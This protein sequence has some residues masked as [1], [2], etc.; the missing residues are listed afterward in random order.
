MNWRRDTDAHLSKELRFH[1]DEH[2]DA[3]IAQGVEPGEAQRRARLALG[4]VEQVKEQLRD[5]R[6]ARWLDELSQ[7]LRYALRTL[8]RRPAFAAVVISTIALGAGAT[9]VMFTVINS[10]LLKPLAYPQ[11]ER[12]VTLQ[13][14]TEVGTQYGNRWAFAYPN[15]LDCERDVRSLTLAAWRFALGSVT[16][17][18]DPEYVYGRQISA[19]LFSMLSVPVIQGRAFSEDEDRPGTP[20]VAVIG[21]GLWQRHY[22]GSPTAVGQ[23]IVFDGKPYTVIGVLPASFPFSRQPPLPPPPR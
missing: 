6:P 14:Q 17:P 1:I 4:G 16:Q 2:A 8:A 7:D 15:Y 18:G 23:P 5:V 10:V 20:A 12:L 3:L 21:Y 13:E 9:T 22:G 11:P 19:R